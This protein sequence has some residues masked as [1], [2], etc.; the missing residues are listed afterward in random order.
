MKQRED[1]INNYFDGYNNFDIKKMCKDVDHSI[2][3]EN[4]EEGRMDI[5][6]LGLP[7]FTQQAEKVTTYFVSRKI[8]IISFNHTDEQTEA[9]VVFKALLAKDIS[10]KFKAGD[11]LNLTGKSIFTFSGNKIKMI[12][13]IS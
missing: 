8:T 7:S 12:R 6:I 13:D 9:E 10:N 5:L 2:R 11:E 3:F 4:I 1:I